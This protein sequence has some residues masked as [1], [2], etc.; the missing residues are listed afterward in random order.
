MLRVHKHAIG[1]WVN[2]IQSNPIMVEL[3]FKSNEYGWINGVINLLGNRAANNITKPQHL[4]Q[5]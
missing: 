3:Q 4:T 1:K 5:I 2:P